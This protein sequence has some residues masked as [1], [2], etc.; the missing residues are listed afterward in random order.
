LAGLVKDDD[1]YAETKKAVDDTPEE[2]MPDGWD[3]IL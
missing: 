2:E 3:R 1:I